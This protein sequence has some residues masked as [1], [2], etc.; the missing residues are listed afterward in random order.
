MSEAQV[1]KSNSAILECLLW[2]AE[3]KRRPV[4]RETLLAEFPSLHE[5]NSKAAVK[6]FARMQTDAEVVQANLEALQHAQLPVL[7]LLHKQEACMLNAIKDGQA[8]IVTV[9]DGVVKKSKLALEKLNARYSG[10]AI[11][12]RESEYEG[13]QHWFWT[14]VRQ[15]W[16]SFREVIIASVMI[17]LFALALPLFM[18]NVYDR[19][20][21]NEAFDTLWVLAVGVIFVFI[22][23][24]VLKSL[25]SYFVDQQA[26][27]IDTHVFANV[28][29]RLLAIPLANR[30][31]SVGE[32]L[33]T[34]QSFEGLRGMLASS[35]IL[36]LVDLPFVLLFITVI[37]IVAGSLAWI[38][39]L[40]IPIVLGVALLVQM[41]LDRLSK[42]SN[43]YQAAKQATVLESLANIE[44]VKS[45]TAE[46]DLQ[47]KAEH[48][49]CSAAR[50]RGRT[51][52]LSNLAVNTAAVLQQL[53][54]VLVIIAGVYMIAAGNLTMGALVASSILTGRALSPMSRAASVLTRLHQ[55]RAIYQSMNE[56]MS[57]PVERPSEKRY[58]KHASIKGNIILQ[59][60]EFSHPGEQ[61]P[62]LNGVNLT[63]Q[64][65]EKVA[66]I[67]RSGSGKST[68]LKL[69]LGLYQPSHGGVMLDQRDQQ[70]I[71][72]A[73][74][75]RDF[76]YV[77]QEPT[78]MRGTI[79][80]NLEAGVRGHL[81]EEKVLKALHTSGAEAFIRQ[82][83]DGLERQVG[84]RGQQLSLG[85]RQLLTIARALVMEPSVILLD[86]PSSSL[87][88]NAESVLRMRLA[89]YAKDKTLVLVTHR[90]QL[91][92]LVDRIIVL[93]AGRVLMDGPKQQVLATLAKPKTVKKQGRV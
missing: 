14:P 71:D 49:A 20:V 33:N 66:I 27:N 54:T 76:G 16:T 72:P 47:H 70:Q 88:D 28:F 48:Y 32:L 5:F 75:R 46:A 15:A 92:S 30:P 50:V 7:L 81:D 18:M 74:I 31:K 53:A 51:D 13:Q 77:S 58:A 11:L 40:V 44:S 43:R 2:Y 6:A 35:S 63:I 67:G 1:S 29:S 21:P 91:L 34:V 85:Q 42:L 64:A 37:A 68:L 17:N 25:R 52:M 79:L 84:E 38:P 73:V 23:D 55:V 78:L 65:G 9:T 69:M 8:E 89:E 83:A 39:I 57:L 80:E 4:A 87:D 90:G 45:L 26:K 41:P 10:E 86:E 82:H 24:F 56:V 60:I 61:K 36:V 59:D 93:E 19:V 22:F 12:L 62:T 3:E